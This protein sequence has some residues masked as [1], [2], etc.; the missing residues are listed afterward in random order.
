[1]FIP[2]GDEPNPRETPFVNYA[3]IVVNI[4]AFV[5]V[6]LPL[7]KQPISESTPYINE[8]LQDLARSNG[9][10]RITDLSYLKHLTSY[11]VFLH[12]WGFRPAS[13]SIVTILSSMFLHG[14]WMHLLGNMLFLWIFGD[15]VEHHLG[16]ARY[17]SAY[18][19]T[20][21]AAT[22]FFAM[23]QA[24]STIP[25]V[26]ASG[27][28]SGVLGCYYVWFSRNEVRVLMVLF[29]FVQVISIPARWV[30]LFYL[31]I[32]NIL[33][34][35]Q[36][37][38]SA[39]A[40]GAHIGGFFAGIGL[41]K[42]ID[43]QKEQQRAERDA[44]QAAREDINFGEAIESEAWEDALECY[45]QMSMNE[46][47]TI[48]DWDVINLVDGLTKSNRY[49]A[50]LAV[51]QRFIGSRPTSPIL[52][53]AHLRAGLIHLHGMSRAPAAYQHFL[54]VLDLNPPP[55]VEQ[56]ARQGLSLIESQTQH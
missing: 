9:V 2:I 36:G 23:F 50:G 29:I 49:E 22:L 21:V 53:L 38:Q 55:E 39:V 51:L 19:L 4:A 40:H 24:D 32:D 48:G 11:D 13:P 46:R 20:G 30:L 10:S 42:Y 26:G 16:R 18:L 35:L 28:I 41:A 44:A 27:A 17:L 7:S 45:A 47:R 8:F 52:S 54:T 6:Y 33:P 25:L 43:F 3:L 37:G 14:G 34:V 12:Q 15:N 31:I 5:L 56:A 1:M